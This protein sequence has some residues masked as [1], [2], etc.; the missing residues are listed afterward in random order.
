ME[1]TKVKI[2]ETSIHSTHISLE[3]LIIQSQQVMEIRHPSLHVVL[4]KLRQILFKYQI[5]R[6]W[7]ASKLPHRHTTLPTHTHI[8]CL[9]KALKI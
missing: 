7:H 5:L 1:K 2:L 6:T 9:C 3:K 4:K 8:L